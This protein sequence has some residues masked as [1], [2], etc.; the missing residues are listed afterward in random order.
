[1]SIKTNWLSN[2]DKDLLKAFL[3]QNMH[4]GIGSLLRDYDENYGKTYH[5]C[6]YSL[7]DAS[8]EESFT[9]QIG[10]FG[11]VKEIHKDNEHI[12]LDNFEFVKYS[13]KFFKSYAKFIAEQNM[14]DGKPLKINGLTYRQDLVSKFT[15]FVESSENVRK[16]K[17]MGG[18]TSIDLEYIA[19]VVK[20][21][22][23]ELLIIEE[24]ALS[25]GE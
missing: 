9:T 4:T 15:K 22:N 7:T 2:V 14:F 25:K 12:L 10:N 1:M 11:V 3:E 24:G 21:V 18:L 23:D 17:F 19:S 16:K 13:P 6:T 20:E 5:V 8:G